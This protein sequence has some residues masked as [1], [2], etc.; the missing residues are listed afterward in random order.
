[1]AHGA[2]STMA[3]MYLEH[4]LYLSGCRTAGWMVVKS[5]HSLNSCFVVFTLGDCLPHPWKT[6]ILLARFGQM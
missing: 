5:F 2:T 1:M 6:T 4:W 3:L